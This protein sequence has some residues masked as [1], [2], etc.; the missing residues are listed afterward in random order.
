MITYRTLRVALLSAALVVGTA[1][2]KEPSLPP[3]QA[4]LLSSISADAMRGHLSFLAS[5]A[6]EG[7]GTPSRGLDIAAE[8]IASQFRAAGLEPLGDDGY[9]QTADWRKIAPEKERAKFADAPEPL[10]VRNV[11]G[12]LRGSDPALSKTY[13]LV[14]A[15]YD[16]LGIR[17][18]K[19]D[20][21]IF[22]GANDDGSGTVSVIE[23]ARAFA[24]QK[25][26]PKRSIVFMTVFGEEHGLVGSRYYGAHP[27][28][29]VADTVA[30]INLEQIGRT[31]DSEGPQVRAAAITGA[32]YSEVADVLRK[33]GELTGIRMTKHPV[34]SDRYFAFSDN[35]ALADLGVPAH[36]ISVAYDYPDYHGAADTW[37]K[38]DY[39]NMAAVDRTVALAIWTI[40]NNPTAPRW[41]DKNPKAAKYVEAAKKLRGE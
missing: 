22:N 4:S 36:T 18:D 31:D 37:D 41:N 8:Y 32:D 14:T 1:Q 6:L 33:A 39:P 30:N 7:R 40:A 9:F 12:V 2:A 23:L 16:H 10:T 15:H 21:P 25:E 24:A 27:L 26:R 35:Q 28:V 34:N 3:E 29:P 13:I 17:K 20:D 38:I 5:D 19:G 11:V